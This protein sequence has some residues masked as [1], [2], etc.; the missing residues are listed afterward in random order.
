MIRRRRFLR[1]IKEDEVSPRSNIKDAR[2]ETCHHSTPIYPQAS[3]LA[4]YRRQEWIS[5][6]MVGMGLVSYHNKLCVIGKVKTE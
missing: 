2:K 4:L 5:V 6:W 3:A 1:E